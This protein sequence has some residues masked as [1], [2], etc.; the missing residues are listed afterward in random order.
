LW[1]AS[2]VLASPRSTSL[3]WGRWLGLVVGLLLIVAAIR[4]MFGKKR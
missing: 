1:L 3:A 2:P 4:A